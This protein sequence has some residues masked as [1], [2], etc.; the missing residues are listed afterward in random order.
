MWETVPTLSV[1][2][3]GSDPVIGRD[4]DVDRDGD[5]DGVFGDMV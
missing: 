2:V 4:G 1:F 5:W 3:R